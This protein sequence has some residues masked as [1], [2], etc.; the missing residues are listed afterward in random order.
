MVLKIRICLKFCNIVASHYFTTHT[1]C[2]LF[3][4]IHLKPYLVRNLRI[5]M[6]NAAH[7]TF[8]I[9]EKRD[10]LYKM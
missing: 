4:S 6:S 3:F 1:D 10:K 9:S 8:K 2:F 7:V 5:S